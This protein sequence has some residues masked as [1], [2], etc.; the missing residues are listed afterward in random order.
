[1]KREKLLKHLRNNNCSLL[2]EG[3]SHSIY[4]NDNNDEIAPVPRHSDVDKK[5]VKK[6]CKELGIDKPLGD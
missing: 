4:I 5:M 2:R 1:M 6:I 3:G